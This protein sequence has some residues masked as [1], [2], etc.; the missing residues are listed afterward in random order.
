MYDIDDPSK[1]YHVPVWRRQELMDEEVTLNGK[2]A[3]IRGWKND[4]ATVR[5]Y[6]AGFSEEFAW[7]TVEHVVKNSGG[8]FR[9]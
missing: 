9:V 3:A 2:R 6:D 7:V 1:S 4:F 5:Q 8:A